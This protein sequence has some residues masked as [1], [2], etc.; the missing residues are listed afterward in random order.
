[1]SIDERD[2][3]HER[4]QSKN[5]NG[6][7]SN[8]PSTDDEAYWRQ[9]SVQQQ[10]L[11]RNVF[12]LCVGVFALV[13]IFGGEIA[14][15][16][17]GMSWPQQSD[18]LVLDALHIIPPR[19]VVP[20]QQFPLSGSIIQY[21]QPKGETAKFIVISSKGRTENCVVKL[22]SWLDG[23]PTIE[24]F[25][26]VGE[27]AETQLVPLGEYRTKIACGKRWYGR[28]EMFGSGTV[29]SIGYEPLR[30]WKVDKNIY[31]AGLTL[32][33]EINGNFKTRES[34]WEKF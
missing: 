9:K 25:V 7:S 15:Y 31:G 34:Y 2:Y 32:T 27:Q 16:W 28:S 3:Y 10:A 29:V 24:M 8:P 19:L 22:E 4:T 5:R 13:W 1:M 23:T 30:F 14:R 21:Q 6:V 12:I 26:R 18:K 20:E 11:K 33:K 17:K